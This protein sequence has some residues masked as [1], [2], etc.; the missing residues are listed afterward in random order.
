MLIVD[1]IRFGPFAADY[2]RSVVN[3]QFKATL[4]R[5]FDRELIPQL[6]EPI[7]S[8]DG[9]FSAT[10]DSDRYC[11]P[12]S[13]VR[14]IFSLELV[15]VGDGG[16]SELKSD[17]VFDRESGTFSPRTGHGHFF[18]LWTPSRKRR[19]KREFELIQR[20][21]DDIQAN[22]TSLLAC[23]ICGGTLSAINNADIF[24]VRCPAKRCFHYNYHKDGEGRLSHGH[25]F[26]KH[27]GERAVQ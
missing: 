12:N 25:F 10:F 22:R 8:A 4:E 17:V 15:L 27:P 6:D 16:N 19:R 1:S 11:G 3:E 26:T 9:T 2:H 21:V 13:L 7:V 18:Y 24:D 20:L 23:P 5:F 14:D